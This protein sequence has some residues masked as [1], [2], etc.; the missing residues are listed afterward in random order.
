MKIRVVW[1]GLNSK[2]INHLGPNPKKGGSPPNDR[3]IEKKIKVC[4]GDREVV[5]LEI[6]LILV[7][8]IV[9]ISMINIKE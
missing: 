9:E 3:R 2:I 8:M 4:W 5:E 6:E 7:V 1:L